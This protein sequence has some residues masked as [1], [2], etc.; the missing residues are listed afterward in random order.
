MSATIDKRLIRASRGAHRARRLAALC[1]AL[2][3]TLP[4]LT[5][6]G[7]AAQETAKAAPF[8]SSRPGA[9]PAQ[10]TSPLFVRTDRSVK[11]R[12]LQRLTTPPRILILGGS[13]ATRIEPAY[14]LQLTGRSGF[15]LAFQNG[16][17]EDAWAF[18]NYAHRAFP[19]TPLQVVWFVHVEAFREQGLSP[20]LVQDE[21]LSH[22][23][24]PALIAREK[25]KLPRSR[26]EVPPGRDLALTRFGADGVVFRNRYDLAEDRGRRLSHAIDC[27]IRTALERYDTTTAALYPRSQQYFDK[28]MGLLD[29]MGTTQVVVLT[30]L[31]PRLLAA[32]RDAGWSERHAEVVAYLKRMQ[33][34]HGFRL[35]DLSELSSIGG[36]PDGF[37][38][39]FHVKRANARRLIRTIVSAFPEAFGGG[40]AAAD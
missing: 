14:F 28:T 38:D 11:L 13:R 15:N 32:V 35:L 18:V 7:C 37:Y 20:G 1:L 6:A 27:S 39:G 17:P 23:F 12:L 9:A 4:V 33:Q 22:W 36:D 30:P 19:T 3:L 10:P 31:H 2:G 16:R 21:T 40:A 34:R 5:A 25:K 24:P 8:A 26:N 29:Q